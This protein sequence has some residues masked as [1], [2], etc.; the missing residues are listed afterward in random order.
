MRV[1]PLAFL[2]LF[3]P[4]IALAQSCPEPLASARR[5]VLVTADTMD[6]TICRQTG[7]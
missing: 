7:E 5:L 1:A 2:A 3:A 6:S 4:Q